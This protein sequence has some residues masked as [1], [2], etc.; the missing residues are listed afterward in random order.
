MNSTMPAR[1]PGYRLVLWL[2]LLIVLI[3]IIL[4]SAAT[5]VTDWLWYR[6]LGRTDVYWTFYWGRW[7]LG[8]GVGV[9]FTAVLLGNLFAALRA[10]PNESW[11]ELG[12]QF[13]GHT[14]PH[15]D[16]LVRSSAYI[17]TAVLVLLIGVVAGRSAAEFWP[18]MLLFRNSGAFGQVDPIF[19]KDLA[20]YLFRLPVWEALARWLF[21]ALLLAFIG[22]GAVY[23]LSRA[24]RRVRGMTV[25]SPMA[26]RHLSVLLAL[27]F[28][29]RAALYLFDR[30]NL[31]MT[32]NGTI[33][34]P[35]Y[36]DVHA[37]MPGLVLLAVVAALAGVLVLVAAGRRN[38]VVPIAAFVG[39]VILSWLVRSAYPAFIQRF[40]VQPNELA[41][42]TPYLK[43]HI[44]FTRRAYGLAD[45]T[46]RR[47][48]STSR[49]TAAA[50]RESP[51][52]IR[53]VRLWDYRP[54]QK[55][56]SQQQALR[57]YY[58]INDVDVDRYTVGGRMRQVMLAARELNIDQ[59]PGEQS[60]VNRHLIYTHGYG[61]VMSPV[62]EV[63]P[64][65]HVP[66]F[67]VSDIPPRPTAPELAV[68]QP[69]IYFG[70]QTRDYVIVKTG[71]QEFDYPQGDKNAYT[72]Y[73]GT[74]GISLSNPFTRL[75][76]AV[77]FGRLDLLLSNYITAESRVLMRQQISARVAAVAPFLDFDT[78][79]YIILGDDGRLY[80]MLEGYTHSMYYPYAQYTTLP[81]LG[82]SG[83]PVNYL[84]SPVRAVVD[85]YN[86]TVRLFTTEPDEPLLRAWSGVFPGLFA[87]LAEMP[88]GLEHHLRTPEGQFNLVSDIYTRFHMTEPTAFYGREDVWE[89]PQE[90]A[91]DGAPGPMEAYYLIMSLPGNPQPEYLL[92]RPYTPS[93]RKNMVAWLSARSDPGHLGEMMVYDFPKRSLVN[94]PEQVEARINTAPDISQAFTLWGQA[95]SSIVRGNL[96]V[97]PIDQS[98]LYVRPIYLQAASTQ[99]PE[100]QR[101]IVADQE[102]VIMR[103][104]LEEALAE[105]TG[106]AA[107]V[108]APAPT[109]TPTAAAP[110]RNA[111]ARSALTHLRAAEA[112]QRA[113]DWATYGKEIAAARRD[114]EALDQG[115]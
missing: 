115:R 83:M 61:V 59:I 10:T 50:V 110:N 32:N 72:N 44:D 67:F 58:S 74:A 41:L 1:A 15:P 98:I 94:G 92:I 42:E 87:P 23:L 36:T 64:Q 73:G 100:L 43:H 46:T 101:V 112:A 107:P 82:E 109:P 35:A 56:F 65:R 31:M 99:I 93:G 4:P 40:R 77:R 29:T 21:Y 85:A 88:A 28:F 71:Q 95:G 63:D 86:G 90:S 47:F 12:D 8:L 49:V 114:L 106:G 9:F 102:R 113:G 69:A 57:T 22:S 62:N 38:I 14:I 25:A 78:D 60:W 13:F 2:L 79:P 84:R 30:F 68:T 96:L 27:L 97:I 26:E 3:A 19:G 104:T 111:L 70:E 6:E 89:I 75:C 33:V 54:L 11:Q 80:W 34:G 20:F 81:R 91:E 17:I 24:I 39:V 48:E 52:T 37:R 66:N 105:L 51:A 45:V 5:F 18:Q 108:P 7:W 103:P 76:L 53:N 16:R 55:V